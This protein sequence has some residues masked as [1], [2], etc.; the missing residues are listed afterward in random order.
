MNN[1]AQERSAEYQ[2]LIANVKEKIKSYQPL[3]LPHKGEYPLNSFLSRLAE[4]LEKEIGSTKSFWEDSLDLKEP[5]AHVSAHV[6]ISVFRAAEKL[7]QSPADINHSIFNVLSKNHPPEVAAIEVAG[8]FLNVH[9]DLLWLTKNILENIKK[10]GEHYGWSSM[11]QGKLALI[12]YSS[13]NIAKP[14]GIGHIRS[15][16]IG[17]ALVNLYQ[18][19]GWQVIRDN[20]LGDWGTQ[21]GKLL[22]ALDRWGNRDKKPEDY[23]VEE[24]KDLYVKYHE[25]ENESLRLEVQSLSE[26]LAKGDPEL[27]AVWKTLRLKSI[28]DFKDTYERLNV[29][30]DIY[31]GESFFIDASSVIND[32]LE[33]NACLLDKETGAVIVPEAD[34]LPSVIMRKSDGTELYLGRDLLA[35]RERVQEFQPQEML[36][37]VGDEQALHFRHLFSLAKKMQYTLGTNLFHINF[38]LVLSDGKKMSTRKGSLI[39]LDKLLEESTKHSLSLMKEKGHLESK[40]DIE[41]AAEIVG[42]GAVIYN[43][44]RQTRTRNISFDWNKML[45][46]QGG[47]SVYLQY[48]YAR[49][50]SVLRKFDGEKNPI[51]TKAPLSQP[52]EIALLLALARFPFVVE[53]AQIDKLPH[54][55]ATYLEELAQRFNTFYG[56][57]KVIDTEDFD[58]KS[59]RHA[60]LVAVSQTI[61]N[62]LSLLNIKTLE[63]L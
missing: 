3:D 42:V 61:R 40:E 23:S 21:F 24:L 10:C 31:S 52:A 17:Q 15:T 8:P 49:I 47:S 29:D 37:V 32:C 58:L 38:G 43:D 34:G 22:V 33:T 12:E 1:F 50:C 48:T 19:T 16:I 59:S 28:S 55:L 4:I 35:L 6:A 27:I 41:K 60:L 2:K 39:E 18:A 63:R 51:E 44:L 45:D 14:I 46:L 9:F 26:R 5:P 25:E 11:H 54:H 57:I 20:F 36:Y 53:K 30:F 62:G 13:P 7:G 56:E